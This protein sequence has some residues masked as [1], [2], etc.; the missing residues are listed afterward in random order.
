MFWTPMCI[1]FD[2]G[3]TWTNEINAKSDNNK[4]NIKDEANEENSVNATHDSTNLLQN[5][6][7]DGGN[8]SSG[9]DASLAAPVSDVDLIVMQSL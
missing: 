7:R 3:L 5:V 8:N 2:A 4:I 1:A 9:V 6:N